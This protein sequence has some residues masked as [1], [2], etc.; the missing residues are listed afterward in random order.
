MTEHSITLPVTGMTCVNCAMNIERGV[1]KLAGVRNVNVNF[2][3]ERTVVDFDP[4]KLRVRDIVENI[5][6]SG[7]KVPTTKT[8]LPVN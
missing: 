3:A 5:H 4:K 7:F 1:K 8:E 2:A 6:N